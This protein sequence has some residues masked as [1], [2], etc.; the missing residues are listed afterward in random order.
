M[1]I[2]YHIDGDISDKRIMFSSFLASNLS[3]WNLQIEHLLAQA[4]GAIR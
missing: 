4:F 2:N 1:D 3:K